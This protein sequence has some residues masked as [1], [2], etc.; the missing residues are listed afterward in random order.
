MQSSADVLYKIAERWN[1]ARH[2]RGGRWVQTRRSILVP[3]EGFVFGLEVRDLHEMVLIEPAN[4]LVFE[5]ILNLL[6][7]LE[8]EV[9][10]RARMEEGTC[11]IILPLTFLAPA[12]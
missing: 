5:L 1:R 7:G 8:L 9:G 3:H 6:D 12:A 10:R 2:L 11:L 4:V